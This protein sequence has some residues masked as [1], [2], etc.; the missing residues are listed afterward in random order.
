MKNATNRYCS[1]DMTP[2]NAI[3]GTLFSLGRDSFS[4]SRLFAMWCFVVAALL[5]HMCF[6]WSIDRFN[7]PTVSFTHIIECALIFCIFT[8]SSSIVAKISFERVRGRIFFSLRD[9]LRFAFRRIGSLVILPGLLGTVLTVMT[10]VLPTIAQ[11]ADRA[12][13]HSAVVSLFSLFFW[14][15]TLF[16]F[17]MAWV[18][19]VSIVY[20]PAI[21]ASTDEISLEVLFQTFALAFRLPFRLLVYEALLIAVAL[22]WGTLFWVIATAAWSAWL[23]LFSTGS[24]VNPGMFP[25]GS[26][27]AVVVAILRNNPLKLV[28]SILNCKEF[29]E[30]GLLVEQVYSGLAGSANPLWVIVRAI[31]GVFAGAVIIAYP[32]TICANG[33]CRLYIDL[34]RR[35]D[36]RNLIE[37]VGK[38]ELSGKITV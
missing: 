31:S 2:E 16:L 11:L 29:H 18:L 28:L 6:R 7:A 38:G 4:G 22:F 23:E 26:L 8:I 10:L 12:G 20:N 30:T 35:L 9:A 27:D 1:L 37:N 34:R 33:H 15:Y 32:L 36:G 19:A 17:I 14:C 13:C 21:V 24:G 3:G 25:L 5:L